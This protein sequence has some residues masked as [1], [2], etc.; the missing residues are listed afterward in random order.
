MAREGK[1]GA[2]RAKCQLNKF[3][4]YNKGCGLG[5]FLLRYHWL[6]AQYLFA[7]TSRFTLSS[8]LQ[9]RYA[10]SDSSQFSQVSSA[11]DRPSQCTRTCVIT[12]LAVWS[13]FFPKMSASCK[14]TKTHVTESSMGRICNSGCP[15][16]DLSFKT[17][18]T[19]WIRASWGRESS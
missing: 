1:L 3:S 16:N 13:L 11:A 10:F 14:G 15:K 19:R 6:K 17:W 7:P 18:N 12:P 8:S 4:F 9:L 5:P 2:F